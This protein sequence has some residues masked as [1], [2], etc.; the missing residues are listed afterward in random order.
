MLKRSIAVFTLLMLLFSC[1]SSYA[2]VPYYPIDKE[3]ETKIPYGLLEELGILS[4]DEYITMDSPV[5]KGMFLKYIIRM[6]GMNE[7]SIPAASKRIFLDVSLDSEY[8]LWAEYGYDRGI[9]LGNSLGSAELE[10]VLT[11]ADAAV[12]SVRA[13]GYNADDSL[14][15]GARNDALDGLKPNDKLTARSA[16]R[17]I[18]NT[19]S[20]SAMMSRTEGNYI[21]D[22][23]TILRQ[24]FKV[25]TYSGVIDDD[26]VININSGVSSL[27]SDQISVEGN[28]YSVEQGKWEGLAGR[29]ADIY[30]R[31]EQGLEKVLFVNPVKNNIKIMKTENVNLYSNGIIETD[32][33][34]TLKIS[35]TAKHIWNFD[36]VYAKD[37]KIVLPSDGTI[38]LTDNNSDNAFD[39]VFIFEA[40]YGFCVETNEKESTLYINQGV[41]KAYKLDEYESYDIYDYDRNEIKFDEISTDTLLEIYESSDKSRLVI[42]AQNM[43]SEYEVTASKIANGKQYAILSDGTQIEVSPHFGKL[44]KIII[45]AGKSYKMTFD[46]DGRIAVA[47]EIDKGD[48]VYGYLFDYGTDGAFGDNL[49]VAI[50]N[51]NGEMI[52]PEVREKL[53]VKENDTESVFT[54]E[55]LLNKFNASFTPQ[56]IRYALDVNGKLSKLEYP[57]ADRFS[58][59]FRCVGITGSATSGTFMYDSRM[60]TGDVYMIGGQVMLDSAKT[61]VIC[62]PAELKLDGDWRVQKVSESFVNSVYYQSVKG[63][64]VNPDSMAAEVVVMPEDLVYTDIASA[65]PGLISGFEE[66]YDDE[67]QEFYDAILMHQNGSEVALRLGEGV[68]PEYMVSTTGEVI[69]LE[70]GDVI[71]VIKDH[72]NEATS[73]KLLFDESTRTCY[74]EKDTATEHTDKGYGHKQR[75]NYGTPY[76]IVGNAM[77]LIKEGESEPSSD[78]FRT[79]VGTIYEFDSSKREPISVISANDIETLSNNADADNKVFIQLNYS[80]NLITILY[81]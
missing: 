12:M 4:E 48:F 77:Y 8:A 75:T 56:L 73:I 64:S 1:L 67:T 46:S 15:L 40:Q 19:L 74:G 21:N 25:K 43:V 70:V 60:R 11:A 63:Y 31:E 34:K 37:G 80:K 5:T 62:V 16:M 49:T 22:N 79:D 76:K 9:I 33:K 24:L 36:R 18:W 42:F 58:N 72:K 51:V 66:M 26:S 7:S 27:K 20:M 57:S 3:N 54:S 23:H 17:I 69:P 65:V 81:K 53:R 6:T 10:S 2:A 50:F 61:K 47:K 59:G 68:K 45:Q 55:A 39:C 44:N 28:V 13:A 52:T 71:K 78:I 41:S 14:M 30:V 32:N 38:I 29:F 35:D